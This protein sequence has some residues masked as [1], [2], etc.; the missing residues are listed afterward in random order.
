MMINLLFDSDYLVFGLKTNELTETGQ[1][2]KKKLQRT[3]RIFAL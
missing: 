2:R 3:F 1:G